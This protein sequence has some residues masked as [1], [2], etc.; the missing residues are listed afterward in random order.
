MSKAPGSP[1]FRP[2]QSNRLLPKLSNLS[3]SPPPGDL[4]QQKVPPSTEEI[5]PVPALAPVVALEAPTV[6]VVEPDSNLKAQ[7]APRRNSRPDLPRSNSEVTDDDMFTLDDEGWSR[8][9]NAG[10]IE[11]MLKLGEGVSGAVSKCRLR[12]SG[13]VFAIKVCQCCIL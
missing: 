7:P 8:V 5:S 13:Q 1:S 12:K 9:A 11:E 10:G 4:S 6:I 3:L 2:P